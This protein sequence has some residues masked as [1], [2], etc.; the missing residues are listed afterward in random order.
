MGKCSE[1]WKVRGYGFIKRR[2][3]QKPGFQLVDVETIKIFEYG[4]S[5]EQNHFS[6]R[7]LQVQREALP[8]LL[9]P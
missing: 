5:Q 2:T 3:F 1:T 7:V 9:L 6:F 8:A 4:G